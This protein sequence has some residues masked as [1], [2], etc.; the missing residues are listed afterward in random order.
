MGRNKGENK[1]YTLT[2]ALK[3]QQIYHG[4]EGNN[5]HKTYS[6]YFSSETRSRTGIP[7]RNSMIKVVNIGDKIA[8]HSMPL[9]TFSVI[10][11]MPHHKIISPK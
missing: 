6:L 1:H 2:N 4:N 10:T 8:I 7:D 5:K 9:I 3:S 11:N